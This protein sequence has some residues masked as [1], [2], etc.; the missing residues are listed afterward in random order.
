MRVPFS[1]ASSPPSI[2]VSPESMRSSVVLPAPLRPASVMRSPPSSLKETPRNSG[3]P[4]TSLSNALAITTAMSP[5]RHIRSPH[6]THARDPRRVGPAPFAYRK[7]E[8][9]HS[10]DLRVAALAEG[11]HGVVSLIQL[12]ALGFDE[13]AVWRRLRVGRLH[14]LNR[15]VYAVGHRALT[16]KSHYLAAVLACGPGALA[17]HLTAAVIWGLLRSATKIEVTVPRGRKPRAGILVHRSR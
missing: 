15:G 3:A 13:A 12:K 17:S 16:A 1:K 2:P 5:N 10:R 8:G 9:P 11:Q 14:R 7:Q 6:V 4:A